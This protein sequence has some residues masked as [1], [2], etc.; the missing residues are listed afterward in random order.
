MP[1]YNGEK[2]LEK[3]LTAFVSQSYENK[4]LII[5]DGKSTDN[6]HN[7]IKKFID[8]GHP[9]I[10]DQTPDTGIS[11][12]INIG[13]QHLTSSEIFGYL[14]CDDILM[15]Q[16]LAEVSSVLAVAEGIDGVYFDSFSYAVSACE[17]TYRACPKTDFSF[18]N[19]LKLGTIVGLQ[20][21]FIRSN[22]VIEYKFSEFHKYSMDYDLYLRMA[23]NNRSNFAHIG[24]PSTINIMDGNISTNFALSGASEALQSGINLAGWTPRLAY[25]YL[26]IRA[27]MFKA[28]VRK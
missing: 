28:W 25:K 3:A 11:N 6:S 19:L 9:L 12:A 21:I 16:V 18:K 14:G 7:I 2:Y 4:R 24:K 15:P 23:K 13:L 27:F 20:N 1:C 8:A 10:W 17:L 5:V 26:L 22:H